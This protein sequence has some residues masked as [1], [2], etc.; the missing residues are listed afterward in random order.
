M[1]EIDVQRSAATSQIS[2]VRPQSRTNG[3]AYDRHKERM[4]GTSHNGMAS[5]FLLVLRPLHKMIESLGEHSSTNTR[6]GLLRS[7]VIHFLEHTGNSQQIGRLEATQ[8]GKQ[9]LGSGQIADHP[10]PANRNIL[11]IASEA[12]RQRQEQH[13]TIRLI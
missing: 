10:L 4:F 7:R 13:Q 5:G 9:M 11:N 8:I 3:F 6:S 1:G 12:V 2:H